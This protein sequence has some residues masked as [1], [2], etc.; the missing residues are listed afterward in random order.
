MSTRNSLAIAAVLVLAAGAAHAQEAM[1]TAGATNVAPSEIKLAD[2]E[3]AAAPAHAPA[4]AEPMDT[5]QQIQRW[6]ADSPVAAQ[7]QYGEP[8]DGQPGDR[9]V[10]GEVGV[11]VGTGGYRS[12]YVTSIMPLGKNGTLA[13]S[14]GQ[15]RNG[16]RLYRGGYGYGYGPG[17][18]YGPGYGAEYGP[19]GYPFGMR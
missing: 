13:L 12:A 16:Y 18:G 11:S 1:A 5:A 14:V 10:H 3:P 6:L 4:L 8:L 19:G 7:D 15:E 9:K 2:A 17:L